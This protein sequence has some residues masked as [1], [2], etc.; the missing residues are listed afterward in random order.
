V[1]NVDNYNVY[2]ATSPTGAKTL[3]V[4]VSGNSSTSYDDTS[5]IPGLVYSYWVTACS[6]TACSDYS[7]SDTGYRSIA[8]PV[9][10]ASDG[11]YA[12]RVVLSWAALTGATSYEVYRTD[13]ITPP[14]APLPSPL[15]ALTVKTYNDVSAD[16]G[17]TY[18][19]WV[20]GCRGTLCGDFNAPETGY[21]ALMAPTGLSASDGT[22]SF[23]VSL[24]WNPVDS[25]DNYNIYRSTSPTGAKTLLS[26][27][28]GNLNTLF[29]DTTGLPGVIYNYWVTACL[30]TKCSAYGITD[31]GVRSLSTPVVSVSIVLQWNALSGATSYE[32]YRTNSNI[33]PAVPLPTPLSV[34]TTTTY[35]DVSVVSGVTY[36]YWIRGCRATI[37]GDFNPPVVVGLNN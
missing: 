18:Y 20:R 24:A 17:I 14:T 28:P 8:A 3:L 5:A 30:G 31:T 4:N 12:D 13:G 7:P 37:C 33:E 6:G 25:A 16:P 1:D 27:V 11:T 36:Y 21:K 22:S 9:I 15:A 19:Y 2:R 26:N 35:T 34:I 32:I 29:D 10:T 23:V